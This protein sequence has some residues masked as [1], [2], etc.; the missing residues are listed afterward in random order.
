MGKYMFFKGCTIPVRLPRLEKL[1][2]DILPEIGVELEESDDFS[3]CPDPVQAQGANLTYWYASAARNICIAEEK[4]LD[5][6]TMCNGCLN[7]L[8]Q[9]NHNLKKDPALKKAVNEIL[10]AVG[11]EFKGTIEVKHLMQ[12]IK[13]DVTL[14]KLK[15]KVK[16]PLKDL[17][18]AAHP[19]CHLLCPEEI[20]GYDNPV[21]PLNYDAFIEAL[22]AKAID[23]VKKIDCCGVS[24]SLGGA[25]EANN[26][27]IA[28]KLIDAKGSGADAI[29]TGCPFCYTQF[30]M[31]QMLAARKLDNLK[32]TKLPVLY[33]IELIGLALGKSLDDIGYSE[34]KIKPE[35]KV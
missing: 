33:A 18:V 30:D 5:I 19:G 14:D 22:G 20:L 28:S 35:L 27:C 29:S 1:A 2:L 13:D 25:K 21:E 6:I 3:C 23:Y 8:A 7:T 4:G 26:D 16:K 34:H 24:L 9:V 11:K 17:K 15:G 31:G 12:V 32:E 10:S